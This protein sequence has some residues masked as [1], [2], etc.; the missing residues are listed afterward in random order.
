MLIDGQSIVFSSIEGSRAIEKLMITSV[1][2]TDDLESYPHLH[3]Q[4][5]SKDPGCGVDNLVLK[6]HTLSP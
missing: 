6:T 2:I 3:E 1:M 5:V 4:F